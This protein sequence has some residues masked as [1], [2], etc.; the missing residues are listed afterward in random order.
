MEHPPQITIRSARFPAPTEV[1][2]TVE[3]LPAPET[4]PGDE[5]APPPTESPLRVEV[6]SLRCP[7]CHEK[8]A[9]AERCAC[10]E[11]LA[12]HHAACWEEH[13]RCAACAGAHV[14]VLSQAPPAPAPARPLAERRPTDFPLP[15]P[16]YPAAAATYLGV[17]LHRLNQLIASG[18]LPARQVRGEVVFRA[19]HVRDL[20][21]RLEARGLR[22][23]PTRRGQVAWSHNAAVIGHWLALLAAGVGVALSLYGPLGALVGFFFALPALGIYARSLTLR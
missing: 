11:C 19:H 14:L 3:A 12:V 21:P 16:C 6:S 8:V 9:L 2:P 22:I 20:R 5:V 1:E 10:A 4:T 7:F 13:P 17:T 23:E 18:Q 15:D